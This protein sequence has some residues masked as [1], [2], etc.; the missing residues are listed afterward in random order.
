MR[1][2]LDVLKRIQ[3]AGKGLQIYDINIEQIRQLHRELDP[4]GVVYC[5]DGSRDEINELADWLVRNT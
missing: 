5:T 4:A 3:A 2:W 1:E